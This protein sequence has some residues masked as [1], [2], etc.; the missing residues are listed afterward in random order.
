MKTITFFGTKWSKLHEK[1][2]TILQVTIIFFLK[3][4][5]ARASSGPIT[6][7]LTACNGVIDRNFYKEH[8]M[9]VECMS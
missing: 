1:K 8:A 9:S 2:D 5:H 3:Q 7:P 4:G 6:L